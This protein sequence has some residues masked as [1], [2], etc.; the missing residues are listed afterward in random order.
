MIDLYTDTEYLE[1]LGKKSK[2]QRLHQNI[3]Q[4]ALAD[5]CGV[6]RRTIVLFESGKGVHLLTFVRILRKLDLDNE[7]LDLIPDTITIDPFKKSIK[8]RQRSS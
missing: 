2:E 4:Q 7:L 3:S 1:L 5:F 8:K 6:S